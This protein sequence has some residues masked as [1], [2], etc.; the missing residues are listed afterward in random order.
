MESIIPWIGVIG[1]LVGAIIGG[2]IA[3]LNSF[4][5]LREQR[6]RERNK[7]ILSKLEETHE[8]LSK[9][10]EAYKWVI[11][12]RIS[13]LYGKNIDQELQKVPIERL[14]M[15]V[16]F[17]APSLTD[18]LNMLEISQKVFGDALVESVVATTSLNSKE[19]LSNLFERES[20]INKICVD[21]QTE[22]VLISKNYL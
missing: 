10:R 12:E 17:Y 3:F 7:L 22:I 20:G 21:M 14:K 2:T 18:Q 6:K 15:L 9:L 19:A 13:K 8:V 11:H 16:G 5:Q 1:A 4:L